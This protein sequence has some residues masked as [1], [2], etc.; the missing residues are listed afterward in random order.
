MRSPDASNC[1][2]LVFQ[3]KWLVDW[4]RGLL[5]LVEHESS[6]LEEGVSFLIRVAGQ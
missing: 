1:E 5:L 6:D 2:P 3:C 4:K